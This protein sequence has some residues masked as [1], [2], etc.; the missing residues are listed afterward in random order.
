MLSSW[1]EL[2]WDKQKFVLG[3][4]VGVIIVY[5]IAIYFSAVAMLK[6]KSQAQVNH[7]ARM[8]SMAFETGKTPPDTLPDEGNYTNVTVGTYFEDIDNLSIKDSLWSAN[9]YV[10]FAWKGDQ[11]LDPGGKFIVVDGAIT[12]K[13]VMEEYHGEDG[14][15]YQRFRVSAKMIK[16]FDTYRVPIENHMLNIYLEDGGRDG[17]KLRFLADKN[18]NYSS[19]L[20]IPGYRITAVDN[21]VKNHT[22]KSSYGDPRVAPDARKTFSQYIAGLSITRLDYGF[23]F[24]IFLSLFAALALTLSSFFI[25]ASDV[26]PRFALPTGAYFGA[27]ANSYVANSILPPSGTF[28]L[29]DYVAGLGLFTIFLSIA[30]SL[31]SVNLLKRDEK[32]ESHV[33][34]RVMFVAVGIGCVAA[35]IIIPLCARG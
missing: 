19:R 30:L 34:D 33:F 5:I 1:R 3:C 2:A 9:F 7:T 10:W 18:S 14:T 13:E 26:A 22:Y 27:V 6:N 15:N 4:A 23:Y 11:A 16:F 31:V 28:G 24:K 17:T 20:S 32:V 21:V 12:K 25:K 8:N 29:V 35:N